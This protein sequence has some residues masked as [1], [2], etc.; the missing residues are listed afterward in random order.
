MRTAEAYYSLVRVDP[1]AAPE[2]RNL[3][4]LPG[5]AITGL[6]RVSEDE[7]GHHGPVFELLGSLLRHF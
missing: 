6:Q 7:A 3:L 1:A 5:S 2:E 4:M